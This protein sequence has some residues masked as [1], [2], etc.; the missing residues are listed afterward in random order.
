MFWCCL[1]GSF[2]FDLLTNPPTKKQI[3]FVLIR[4]IYS[5]DSW[6]F[7]LSTFS[8]SVVEF[9]DGLGGNWGGREGG[10]GWAEVHVESLPSTGSSPSFSRLKVLWAYRP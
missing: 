4:A 6:I 2:C 1:G 10:A 7:F 8:M 3:I 5:R 9:A